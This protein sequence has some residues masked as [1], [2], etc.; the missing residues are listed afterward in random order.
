VSEVVGFLEVL[1]CEQYGRPAGHHALYELPQVLTGSRIEAG[2]RLVQDENRRLADQ[3]GSHVQAPTHA[4]GVGLHGTVAGLS[5]TEDF[6]HLLSPLP[7][8]TSAQMIQAADQQQ[9][10]APGHHFVDRCEL[11]GQPDT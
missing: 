9:V 8:L 6:Q 4:P 5:E 7:T 3:A 1:G 11:A 2:C 10:F